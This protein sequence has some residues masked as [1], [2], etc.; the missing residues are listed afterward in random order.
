MPRACVMRCPEDARSRRSPRVRPSG[1]Q[2]IVNFR[3]RRIVAAM[4]AHVAAVFSSLDASMAALQASVDSVTPALHS[5]RPAAD[6]WSVAEV[7]EHLALVE[8]LFTT[9]L[10]SP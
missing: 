2:D 8:Q 9:R 5:R 4:H 3:A 7:L 1:V 6:R 10:A